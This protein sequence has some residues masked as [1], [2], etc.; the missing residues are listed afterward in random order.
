[1]EYAFG[2]RPQRSVAEPGRAVARRQRQRRNRP[3]LR[4]GNPPC[5]QSRPRLRLHHARRVHARR[6]ICLGHGGMNDRRR[7]TSGRKV[8]VALVRQLSYDKRWVRHRALH[9]K[10]GVGGYPTSPC[11]TTIASSTWRGT[12]YGT[13]AG[14]AS[15]TSTGGTSRPAGSS[16]AHSAPTVPRTH[17]PQRLTV[18]RL[19]VDRPQRG[20]GR[21]CA[22]ASAHPP[23]PAADRRPPMPGGPPSPPTA[24]RLRSAPSSAPCRSSTSRPAVCAAASAATASRMHGL[25]FS[26]D[27]RT[28]VSSA[29][30][31][32]V[33]AWDVAT[34]APIA[35]PRRPCEP[36]A[37]DRVQQRR[38]HALHL[39]PR[40]RDLRLGHRNLEPVRRAVRRRHERRTRS[41]T[42]T[43][44]RRLRS[45]ATAHIS[46]TASRPA[47]SGSSRLRPGSLVAHFS[48]PGG[49]A[50]DIAW[51]PTAP[52]VAVTAAKGVVQLWDVRVRPRLVRS[53]RGLRSI[54]GQRESG[55]AVAF[56][57]DGRRARRR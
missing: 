22:Y 43:P 8:D 36:R 19:V 6:P 56:S 34:A 14:T 23:C 49:T 20:D 4:P 13:T 3:Y 53:L 21:R 32:S 37:R 24:G 2:S 42:S 28:L 41:S 29:E 38:A 12:R 15:A 52:L 48:V 57:H 54:N 46:P 51:S 30:D 39:Q 7:S 55:E 10:G 35:A 44:S 9:T 18:A 47:R 33:I 31:G 50:D 17:R 40:R 25:R 1:M 45:P 5:A 16:T 26:P 11:P 27:G